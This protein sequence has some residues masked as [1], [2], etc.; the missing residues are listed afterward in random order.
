MHSRASVWTLHSCTSHLI[1]FHPVI[2]YWMVSYHVTS[3]CIECCILQYRLYCVVALCVSCHIIS[4][5]IMLHPVKSCHAIYHIHLVPSSHFVLHC[6]QLFQSCCGIAPILLYCVILC[7]IISNYVSLIIPIHIAFCRILL[8][9]VKCCI[10]CFCWI[11][12][13]CVMLCHVMSY[14][15]VD[16]MYWIKS[17][18]VSSCFILSFQVLPWCIMSFCNML[19]FM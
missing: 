16:I 12:L 10:V 13:H 15:D 3:Y 1:I 8:L 6:V 7:C 17:F 14:C 18:H 5:H 2:R 4:Y 9:F 19:H 11:L